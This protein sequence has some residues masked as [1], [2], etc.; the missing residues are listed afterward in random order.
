MLLDSM[1]DVVPCAVNWESADQR[2]K[3]HK[4]FLMEAPQKMD[5]QRLQFL[6]EVY[7]EGGQSHTLTIYFDRVQNPA[8][9]ADPVVDNLDDDTVMWE[10]TVTMDPS[11]D[12][13]DFANGGKVNDADKGLL[14][15]G[16]LSFS[17]AGELSD[18]TAFV[19]TQ[20]GDG[21]RDK[22]S[23][24][25]APISNNGFPV[26]APNFSGTENASEVWNTTGTSVNPEADGHLIELDLGLRS[27]SMGWDPDA[28][29]TLAELG[30][31]AN[32]TVGMGD[33][34]DQLNTSS[35]SFTDNTGNNFYQRFAS[36]DGYT[37]GD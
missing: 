2:I 25:Q 18:M 32:N 24:V 28:K 21:F 37:H 4:S 17:S 6:M 3:D 10:Y 5:P 1:H 36:Q 31:D 15:T 30:T 35:T 11:E 12:K 20:G 34:A 19:P 22:D 29:G 14:M 8:P 33:R 27:K 26:F 23:W 16:T 13:R 9:P 7:D